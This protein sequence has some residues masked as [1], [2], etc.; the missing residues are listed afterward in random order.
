[1][2]LSA[3]A[4]LIILVMPPMSAPRASAGQHPGQE[5]FSVPILLYHR[6]GPSVADS[7]TVTTAVFESHL[8][9]L[10]DNGYTVIRLAELVDG[11]LGKGPVPKPKSVVITADDGHLSVC[12]V[13]FPLIRKYQVP[14]TLFIYP[15]AISNA[16]YAMTWDQLRNMH[17][18][19]LVDVQSH[20]YWH[21]NFIK[22][23]RRMSGAEFERSVD[24]QLKKSREVIGKR[25]GVSA[26]MLAWPFGL[27]DDWL[28]TRA[29]Q[30]GY[31]AAFTIDGRHATPSDN[32]MAIPRY[33][34]VDADKGLA[35][36]LLLEGK[37]VRRRITY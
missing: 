28:M 31:V 11:Y 35:F 24:M 30:D 13:M 12:T 34:M 7:M 20:S 17:G 22:E 36:R 2:L 26:Y 23:R 9:F 25:L 37:A 29:R 18:S 15:S 6:F 16:S 5:S 8:R 27:Y 4:F 32:V 3:W 33:L 19:G 1:M 14:V 10:R 21:P